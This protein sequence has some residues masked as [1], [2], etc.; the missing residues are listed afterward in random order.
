MKDPRGV[1]GSRG[2]N[3]QARSVDVVV[4]PLSRPEEWRGDPSFAPLPEEGP[5]ESLGPDSEELGWT[6]PEDVEAEA[7]RT[8]AVRRFL[9]VEQEVEL[10]KMLHRG[11]DMDDIA[12]RL[13]LT[14][15][16]VNSVYKRAVRRA[17][18]G[19]GATEERDRQLLL[20]A[21][22]LNRVAEDYLFPEVDE[23]GETRPIN[24]KGIDSALKIMRRRADLTGADA[25]SKHLVQQHVQHEGLEQVNRV[26]EFMDLADAILEAG[27][28][29]GRAPE[30]HEALEIEAH[31]PRVLDPAPESPTPWEVA[32]EVDPGNDMARIHM[33]A[34]DWV[35]PREDDEGA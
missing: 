15:G 25:P 2:A 6:V 19:A 21:G 8:R 29:S 13:G 31:D 34:N 20:T 22:M 30:N 23:D 9:D 16:Q 1:A 32:E 4:A 17:V 18:R 26:V 35:Q 11:L 14:L 28:G 27:Y 24:L 12:Q 10:M 5:E 3:A 33:L 7:R